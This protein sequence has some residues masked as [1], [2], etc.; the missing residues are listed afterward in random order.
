[1]DP[2]SGHGST[3]WCCSGG[4]THPRSPLTLKTLKAPQDLLPRDKEH[5]ALTALLEEHEEGEKRDPRHV[6]GRPEIER[7]LGHQTA[8]NLRHEQEE[9]EN[10]DGFSVPGWGEGLWMWLGR[11]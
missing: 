4:P 2:N 10:L 9:E 11:K 8:K 1:M 3:P 7:I 5:L 6:H